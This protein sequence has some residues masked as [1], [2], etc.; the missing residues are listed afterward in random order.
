MLARV[1]PKGF[2]EYLLLR[3]KNLKKHEELIKNIFPHLKIIRIY[4]H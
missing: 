4:T 2:S 1:C 3:L